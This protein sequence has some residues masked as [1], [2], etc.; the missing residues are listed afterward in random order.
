M[1]VFSMIKIILILLILF[2]YIKSRHENFKAMYNGENKNF[3]ITKIEDKGGGNFKVIMII[4]DCEIEWTCTRKR[5]GE[6]YKYT[7]DY[8]RDTFVNTQSGGA[9]LDPTNGLVEDIDNDPGITKELQKYIDDLVKNPLDGSVI[10][11]GANGDGLCS[12][13]IPDGSNRTQIGN[14]FIFPIS[15]I[16][17]HKDVDPLHNSINCNSGDFGGKL[18]SSEYSIIQFKESHYGHCNSNDIYPVSSKNWQDPNQFGDTGENKYNNNCGPNLLAPSKQDIA[19]KRCNNTTNKFCI[20]D[21]SERNGRCVSDKP[22]DV[23]NN[24]AE[25]K[26]YDY[27]S[28]YTKDKN[29][30][31]QDCIDN[32]DC[33]AINSNGVWWKLKKGTTIGRGGARIIRTQQDADNINNMAVGTGYGTKHSSLGNR[34]LVAGDVIGTSSNPLGRYNATGYQCL[35]RE[36]KCPS[37][38]VFKNPGWAQTLGKNAWGCYDP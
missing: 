7:C 17:Y 15:K 23:R 21:D 4:S 12:F 38:K 26:K 20:W 27:T 25:S 9:C 18:D 19:G 1:K 34:N 13:N 37:G 28:Y 22:D 36:D 16:N 10:T 30:A 24:R 8:N 31:M 11:T 6:E 2:I 29:L 35:I 3:L 32:Y 5:V 14:S 33:N